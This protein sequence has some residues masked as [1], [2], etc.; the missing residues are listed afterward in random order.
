M[1][2]AYVDVNGG[3]AGDVGRAAI[4]KNCGGGW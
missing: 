1:I 2:A 4:G 3:G